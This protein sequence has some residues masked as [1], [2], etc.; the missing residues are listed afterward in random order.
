MLPHKVF[1]YA[2]FVHVHSHN[3][4]K[5]D[6]RDLKCVFLGCS[7]TKKGYKFYHPTSRKNFT[8]MDATFLENESLFQSPNPSPQ[9]K[10]FEKDNDD[11]M[12]FLEFDSL[13]KSGPLTSLKKSI[14]LKPQ[15][16][17]ETPTTLPEMEP[18]PIDE[19]QLEN[20]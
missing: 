2:A 19:I 7:N 3:R 16:L 14:S 17:P 8:S 20:Q 4:G 10:V 9:E 11:T 6:P 5:L 18:E 13:P 1:G 15:N 12:E